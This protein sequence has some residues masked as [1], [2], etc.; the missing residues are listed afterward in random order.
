MKFIKN[1]KSYNQIDIE[2]IDESRVYFLNDLNRKLQELVFDGNEWAGKL[3]QAQGTDIDS[4]TTFLN[5]DGE[6]FSFSKEAD[7]RK[8]SD[9]SYAKVLFDDPIDEI[10]PP[11]VFHY[12]GD[13]QQ[14]NFGNLSSRGSVKMGRVIKKLLP[15][16]SDK[17]LEKLVNNLRSE[18]S[19]YEIKLVKGLDIIKYYKRESCDENSLNYGTLNHSCMMDKV[20]ENKNIFDIY[21]KN[22]ET[23]QLAVMLN[24]E[25]KLVA[26][27]LVWKI[28]EISRYDQSSASLMKDEEKFYSNL[29][30]NWKLV[31]QNNYDNDLFTT[32]VKELY[33]M[34]RVYYTKDWMENSLHKWAINKRMMIKWREQISYNGVTNKPILTVSVNKV[35]YRQFPYLDTFK[36]YDVQSGKLT[37]FKISNRGFELQQLQGGYTSTG[38][39]VE[40]GIDK[41]TNYI[42]R[43]K[44]LV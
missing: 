10:Q 27:A 31:D 3:L 24:G 22:P 4:D 16:I 36:Y 11:R 44:D 19:G 15:Q 17:E 25:G 21:T 23:C 14:N 30:L 34:D 43:F 29:N 32:K 37:N 20:T 1:Y 9:P 41:A 13:L 35:G 39:K 6:N 26:R 38:T 33:L 40:K 12:F 42:R 28:D 18:T 7:V 8:L 5:L 2:S